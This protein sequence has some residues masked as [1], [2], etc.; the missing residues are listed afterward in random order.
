MRFEANR[1]LEARLE[2][3]LRDRLQAPG[4]VRIQLAI[5]IGR[6]GEHLLQIAR[7][8]ATDLLVVGANRHGVLGRVVSTLN[9]VLHFSPCSV[10]VVPEPVAAVA[11]W[12]PQ[13]RSPSD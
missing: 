2:R 9:V 10:L 13:S 5:G 3:D 1:D 7:A 6:T 11:P 8:L 4:D 12:F